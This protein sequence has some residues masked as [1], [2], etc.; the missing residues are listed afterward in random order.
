[1]AKFCKVVGILCLVLTG[2]VLL[3]GLAS[4][5]I[6]VLLPLISTISAGLAL[7]FCGAL[8]ERISV[9]EGLA[10]IR[11]EREP[12]QPEKPTVAQVHCEICGA[13][14]DFDYP[15]CPFCRAKNPLD[16]DE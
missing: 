5:F 12:E 3:F 11:R 7:Y 4:G 16:S 6:W 9:L 1:M 10:G 13:D 8:L 2:I 14:Y 15:R